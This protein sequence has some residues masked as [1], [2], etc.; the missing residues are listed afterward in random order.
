[1]T[2]SLEARLTHSQMAKALIEAR[3]Q[4]A[5]KDTALDDFAELYAKEANVKMA[6]VGE[7]EKARAQIAAL[8]AEIERLRKMD[9]ELVRARKRYE[10]D[11]KEGMP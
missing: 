5:A 11:I 6:L 7:L 8:K 9:D 1:M 3:A 4:I 2:D 10:M